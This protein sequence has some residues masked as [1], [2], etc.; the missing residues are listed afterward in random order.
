[1]IKKKG[2]DFGAMVEGLTSLQKK[3]L[4]IL[5]LPEK[6]YDLSFEYGKKNLVC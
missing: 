5:Q 6:F 1:L 3:T 4:S 2:G